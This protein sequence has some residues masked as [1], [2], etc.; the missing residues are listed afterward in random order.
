MVTSTSATSNVSLPSMA[1]GITP[2]LSGLIGFVSLAGLM[3][4]SIVS[5]IGKVKSNAMEVGPIRPVI[6]FASSKAP[7]LSYCLTVTKPKSAT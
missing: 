3:S 1:T 2:L 7:A 6:K 5:P 4:I